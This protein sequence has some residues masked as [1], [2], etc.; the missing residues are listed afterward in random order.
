MM[1][2][3]DEFDENRYGATLKAKKIISDTQNSDLY[4]EDDSSAIYEMLIRNMKSVDFGYYLRRYVYKAAGFTEDF[5]SVPVK[6]YVDTIV[7]AFSNKGI[8]CSWRPT[9]TR[10]PVAVK[11]WL[12]RKSVS[13]DAVIMLG[14]GLDMNL[15]DIN[16]FL[17]KGLQE[18]SL[19]PKNP[20]ETICW[21]C[22]AN[23]KGYFHFRDLVAAYE[24]LPG[25]PE[26]E[27]EISTTETMKLR[28]EVEDIRDDKTLLRYLNRLRRIDGKTRQSVEARRL[29][30]Q[31]YDEAC[32]YI[33]EIKNNEENDLKEVELGRLRDKLSRDDRY[34]DEQKQDRIRNFSDHRKHWSKEDIS[35][36]NFEEELFSAIPK[37]RNGNLLPI[38]GS[39]LNEQFNGKRLN[40]QHIQEI[41]D[42]TGAINRYDLATMSFFVMSQRKELEDDSVA[43]YHEFIEQTNSML[44]RCGM[45]DLYDAN[46]YDAFLKICMLTEYPLGTYADVWGMAYDPE[47]ELES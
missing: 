42:G 39:A 38:K 46:P 21:Y 22:I 26:N 45:G 44:D 12:T 32:T 15:E 18:S 28:T 8:P 6:E 34:Y 41:L 40:R 47:L 9:S 16:D 14:F 19:S 30:D 2:S 20:V 4:K 1:M 10:L 23:H 27:K 13:R 25:S 11:N 24:K 31:L 35:P 36:V 33:A 29:F 7:D 43:R 5:E 17:T 3:F 37:D